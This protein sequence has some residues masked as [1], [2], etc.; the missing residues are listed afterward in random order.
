MIQC[1]MKKVNDAGDRKHF[2][3]GE[4]IGAKHK[5]VLNRS[6]KLNIRGLQ[7]LLNSK[8]R[9]RHEKEHLLHPIGK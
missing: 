5:F 2:R 8:S 3:M 9:G 6:Q 4:T 7:H 1:V